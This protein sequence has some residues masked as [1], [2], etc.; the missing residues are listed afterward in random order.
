M[1]MAVPMAV[2]C[3]TF[4]VACGGGGGDQKRPVPTTTVAIAPSTTEVG[5]LAAVFKAVPGVSLLEFSDEVLR[6]LREDPT[7]DPVFNEVIDDI[8]ARSVNKAGTDVGVV[9][10]MTLDRTYAAL[11][12]VEDTILSKFSDGTGSIRRV[13][14]AGEDVAVAT[15]EDG[16]VFVVWVHDALVIV[17]F[18]P[19]EDT[20]L[21][22]A[23][24]LVAANTP[25]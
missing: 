9:L 6:A 14:A 10:A 12:G 22:V 15:S 17:V 4:V 25:N 20:L 24:A 16:I 1:P 5:D 2:L 3:C 19:G 13:A 21:P 23:T 7:S 18:G 11:P 8:Q